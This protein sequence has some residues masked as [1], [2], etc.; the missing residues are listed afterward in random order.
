MFKLLSKRSVKQLTT[1]TYGLA[2]GAIVFLIGVG[3]LWKLSR[4]YHRPHHQ[5]RKTVTSRGRRFAAQGGYDKDEI[6]E[7]AGDLTHGL[8]NGESTQHWKEKGKSKDRTLSKQVDELSW[9]KKATTNLL[10]T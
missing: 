3:S 1:I 6:G 5:I 2:C 4:D 9:Q 7:L 10:K 8:Q